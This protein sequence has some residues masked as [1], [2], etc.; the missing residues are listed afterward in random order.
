MEDLTDEQL[1]HWKKGDKKDDEDEKN[2]EEKVKSVEEEQPQVVKEEEVQEMEELKNG[3]EKI[4]NV[5]KDGNEKAKS[6]EEQPQVI[7][8]ED[9]KL[10]TIVVYYNRKKYV[11]HANEVSKTYIIF[12]NQEKVIGEA[13]QTKKSKGEEDVDKA[14]QEL[15]QSKEEVVKGKDDDDGNLKKKPD[16]VQLQLALMESEVDVTLKKRHILT[17]ED[18]NERAFKMACQMSLLHVHLDEL[19]P[20]VLLESFIQRPI[21][22]DK[23]N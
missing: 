3:D 17:D 18:I 5:E 9:S 7:E 6:K 12:F 13:Y 19:L 20:G 21:S 8:D 11:Q 15:A 2:I 10:P 22:Q 4:D 14:S 23:K 16:P 1:D